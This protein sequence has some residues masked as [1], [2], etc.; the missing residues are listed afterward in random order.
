MEKHS[1]TKNGV[2]IYQYRN[3]ASHGFFISLFLRSGSMFESDT[4]NGITHFFEHLAIRN[5]H[6]VMNGELYRELDRHGIEFNAS[7]YYEMVQFYVSGARENFAFGAR[8]ISELLSPVILSSSEIDTERRRIKAEIR[9]S[10]DKSS[11]S[12]FSS[13]IVYE[14]TNLKNPI[15]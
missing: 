8:V 13:G 9:E 2:S 4:D 5:V 10:D 6:K 3:P 12:V 7:T 14:G 1:V 15:T 11:L